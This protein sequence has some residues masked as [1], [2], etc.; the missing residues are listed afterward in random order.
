MTSL[1]LDLMVIREPHAVDLADPRDRLLAP[2]PMVG[3]VWSRIESQVRKQKRDRSCK[4]LM[5]GE[6]TMVSVCS[7]W[8]EF[9]AR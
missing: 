2:I 8:S 9:G 6:L 4:R 7:L 3:T 1:M 5:E